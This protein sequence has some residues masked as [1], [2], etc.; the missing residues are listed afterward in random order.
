MRL[1]RLHRKSAAFRTCV[2]GELGIEAC[3]MQIQVHTHTDA[4]HRNTGKG[5]HA[6]FK[7]GK[8]H[9]EIRTLSTT[10]WMEIPRPPT[11]CVFA[12]WFCGRAGQHRHLRRVTGD[13]RTPP[14]C[15][16]DA[17][18]SLASC[19]YLKLCMCAVVY[20]SHCSSNSS[21]PFVSLPQFSSRICRENGA[22]RRSDQ[23]QISA[24]CLFRQLRRRWGAYGE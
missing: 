15:L 1:H 19:P 24:S 18:V 23:Q 5:A 10:G 16:F 3:R 4:P 14:F 21:F 8:P 17:C 7:Y 2:L 9:T 11:R 13:R 12:Y 6:S 22:D 20:P